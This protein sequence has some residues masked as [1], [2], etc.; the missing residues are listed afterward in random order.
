MPEVYTIAFFAKSVIVSQAFSFLGC[1]AARLKFLNFLAIVD[2]ILLRINPLA[3]LIASQYK[4][5]IF[6]VF[7]LGQKINVSVTNER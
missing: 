2:S 5:N 7:L 3:G 1:Y 6:C 4:V